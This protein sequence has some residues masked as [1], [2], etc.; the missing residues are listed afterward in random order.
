MRFGVEML[1]D[2][3]YH[4]ANHVI[5]TQCKPPGATLWQKQQKQDVWGPKFCL[6]QASARASSRQGRPDSDMDNSVFAEV[7]RWAPL[8]NSC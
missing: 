7:R 2:F 6:L 3:N 8:V 5:I 4:F 1:T